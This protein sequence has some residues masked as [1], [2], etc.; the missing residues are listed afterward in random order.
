[1]TATQKKQE[2]ARAPADRVV[3]FFQSDA[4]KTNRR[5]T[6]VLGESLRF[7]LSISRAK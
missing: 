6:R 1:M 3:L 7:T 4:G 2:H 5:G